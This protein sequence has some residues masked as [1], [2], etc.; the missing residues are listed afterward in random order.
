MVDAIGR[1]RNQPS[2]LIS[3]SGAGI[4]GDRGE[5][6]IPESNRGTSV[7][8]LAEVA[9]VGT[10]RDERFKRQ[11][12]NRFQSEP[13]WRSGKTAEPS[14]GL[15]PFSNSDLKANSAPASNGFHGLHITDI[16][17]LFFTRSRQNPYTV[18]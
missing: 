2:V 4:Y 14:N 9:T 5:E 3:A 7:G 8:F 6:I 12:S 1:V 16:A 17:A 18:R 13:P 15:E 10:Q 11:V